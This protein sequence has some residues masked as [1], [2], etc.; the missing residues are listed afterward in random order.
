MANVRPSLPARKEALRAIE[1]ADRETLLTTLEYYREIGNEWLRRQVIK[2][3]RIDLLAEYVLG[4][5]VRPHHIAIAKHQMLHSESLTLVFRGAG[6]TTIGTVVRNTWDILCNPNTR[7]LL[8]SKA[9]SNAAGMLDEIKGCLTHDRLVEIFGNQI[10]DK[11]ETNSI[12]VAGRDIRAKEPTIQTLGIETALASR[13]FDKV[14]ADDLVDEENARTEHMREKVKTWYYK[15]LHP[16]LEASSEFH[17]LGTFYHY[18]DLWHWLLER[19]LKNST[20]II[21]ALKGKKTPW[22]ERYSYLWMKKKRKKLGVVIFNTQ[23]QLDT[24]AMKG[25]LFD[26]DDCQQIDIDEVP[27]NATVYMGVDLAIGEKDS[28]DFFAIVVVALDK[29]G[30]IYCLDW[31]EGRISFS[32]QT[33]KIRKFAKKWNPS[34]IGIEANQYQKAQYQSVKKKYPDFNVFPLFTDKDKVTRAYHRQGSFESGKV[35]FIK[36]AEKFIER[37]VLLST[38]TKSKWDVFDA[39]DIALRIARKK[40][41]KKR[42]RNEPGVIGAKG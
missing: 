18:A 15:V 1:S 13:H 24:D 29:N 3:K 28:N 26:Y 22:P 31:Y 41:R 11:W 17:H 23:Y 19:E 21:K 16:T 34:K 5:E 8:A 42:R 40:K 36:G 32:K 33:K 35:F 9:Q 2:N 25:E 7:N 4:Y 38:K 39:F 10:G 12:K 6:K 20:L 37:F 27:A 14:Y 30:N